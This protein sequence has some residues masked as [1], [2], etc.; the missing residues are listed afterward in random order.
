ML[1]KNTRDDIEFEQSGAHSVVRSLSVVLVLKEY[2]IP[3]LFFPS[4]AY[5]FIVVSVP[6]YLSLL[7]LLA[8]L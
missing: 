1:E 7:S 2:L 8:W 6:F 4:P 5:S 3:A